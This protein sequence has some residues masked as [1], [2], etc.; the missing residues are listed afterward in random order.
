MKRSAVIL[1]LLL[2]LAACSR[3][4]TTTETA[5]TETATTTVDTAATATETAAATDT[6]TTIPA[7]DLTFA[8]TALMANRY[9]IMAGELARTKAKGEKYKEFAQLMITQHSE[10]LA[11]LEE[12]LKGL[13]IPIPPP[14]LGE[15]FKELYDALERE[16][17][18]DSFDGLYREQMITTHTQAKGLFET[19]AGSG[20]VVPL[21]D[22]AAKWLPVVIE[23]LK[24]AEHL[25]KVKK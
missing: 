15:P 21:K 18:G 13:G 6:T 12:I 8:E 22:Y 1:L 11:N 25:P 2:A 4:E 9:E 7:G 17:A 14:G 3:T 23:H 24:H 10:M 19:E 16:P 20:Q 5:A